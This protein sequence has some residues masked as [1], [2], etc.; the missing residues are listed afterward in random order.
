MIR[1]I[2]QFCG[3]YQGKLVTSERVETKAG[4]N[5]H[6]ET[7]KFGGAH[8]QE[9][10]CSQKQQQNDLNSF[11]CQLQPNDNPGHSNEGRRGLREQTPPEQASLSACRSG[12]VAQPA[13]SSRGRS[14]CWVHGERLL[15]VAASWASVC[16]VDSVRPRLA[17]SLPTNTRVHHH[18]STATTP[19]QHTHTPTR[20]HPMPHTPPTPHRAPASSGPFPTCRAPC[21]RIQ[22]AQS[23][24]AAPSRS[25]R[26]LRSF[27]RH[28][29]MR[30]RARPVPS[31]GLLGGRRQASWPCCCWE[32]RQVAW[33]LQHRAG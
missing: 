29:Q 1:Q 2:P 24:A 12:I 19:N 9:F 5:T 4:H 15:W 31:A 11:K 18:T 16:R 17:G 21:G 6:Q 3:C 32:L 23:A 26:G 8:A 10:A 25:R 22:Q 27:R 20:T 33:T 7:R 13:A 14:A 30:R 28:L